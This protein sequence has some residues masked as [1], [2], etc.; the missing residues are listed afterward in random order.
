MLVASGQGCY[1]G[2]ASPFTQTHRASGVAVVPLDEPDA[3]LEVRIAW[4]KGDTSRAAREFVRSARTVFPLKAEASRD[5]VAEQYL[6]R[7]RQNKTVSR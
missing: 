3:R 1:L 2:I 6:T 7:Q 5:G 4:R